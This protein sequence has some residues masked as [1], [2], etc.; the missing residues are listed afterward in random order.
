MKIYI[1]LISL[2]AMFSSNRLNL[3]DAPALVKRHHF[4]GIEILDR[5]LF[6]LDKDQLVGIR[7]RC[8]Q[9]GCGIVVDAG[10]DLTVSGPAADLELAHLRTVIDQAAIL[11]SSI[12]R[13]AVG[14][15]RF[16]IQKLVRPV[17]SSTTAGSENK[18]KIMSSALVRRIG[19]LYRSRASNVVSYDDSSFRNV[20]DALDRVLPYAAAQ[21]I[22]LA[23]ENH[24]GISSRPE[25]I[26]RIIQGVSCQNFGTCPDFG[27][28][29]SGTDRYAGL[30]MLAPHALHVQAKCWSFRQ[31]GEERTIDFGRCIGILKQA[32]YDGPLA[33]EYESGGDGMEACIMARQ[34]IFR[35]L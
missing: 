27:N 12:V 20:T 6:G 3:A 26:L 24:W 21:G 17:R 32:G 1:S 18:R 10:C 30:A 25:W 7:E 5:Q 4:D 8:R 14:G 29:P 11:G 23:I 35:S 33:V 9:Y 19:Y 2:D 31:D 34:L 22:S 13:I 15:Q 16:S 28:F